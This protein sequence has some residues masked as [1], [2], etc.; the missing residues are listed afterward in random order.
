M[1]EMSE[2]REVVRVTEAERMRVER[3]IVVD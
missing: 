1:G 2:K 3:E